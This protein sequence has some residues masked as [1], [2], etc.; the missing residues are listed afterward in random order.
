MVV[1]DW[2]QEGRLLGE[3]KVRAPGKATWHPINKVKALLPY[4]PQQESTPKT[5]EDTAAALDS[6]ETGLSHRSPFG[7][8]D[9]D[10]DM[11]P[12]IDVSLVLLVFF[13]MTAAVSGP[14]SVLD[15]A[16]QAAKKSLL[17]VKADQYW[18]AITKRYD[19][20]NNVEKTKSGWPVLEYSFGI[21]DVTRIKPTTNRNVLIQKIR[22]EFQS[23]DGD[24]KVSLRADRGISADSV[25]ELTVELQKVQAQLNSQEKSKGKRVEFQF[26]A[27]VITSTQ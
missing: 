6:V 19:S 2:L 23:Q 21:G 24:F 3:D 5:P 8:E 20:E 17:E 22:Q 9:E 15:M 26:F 13:I 1:T 10:V 27:Q 7:A 11:I 4:L 18:I 14:A 25:Q 16:L 12:L